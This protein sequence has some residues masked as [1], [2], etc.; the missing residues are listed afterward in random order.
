MHGGMK[1]YCGSPAGA[2]NYVEAGRVRADDY[3]L[4][5]GTG[6]AERLV[7]PPETG[8]QRAAPLSGDAYE[9]WVAG[10]DP[11]TGV[12]KGRLR[13]DAAGSYDAMR[14]GRM[15]RGIAAGSSK[16][17]MPAVCPCRPTFPASSTAISI[18]TR[19]P[20]SAWPFLGA[21]M[22]GSRR[23]VRCAA[24]RVAPAV[25]TGSVTLAS[26]S[27]RWPKLPHRWPKSLR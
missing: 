9:A 17:L 21:L 16:T 24:T 3:Y 11:D 22:S 14:S 12:A 25:V 18:G 2:R 27:H 1:P 4:A 23:I 15:C 13:H 19:H 10:A 7:A 5:E 20:R 6:V 8:V 26:I